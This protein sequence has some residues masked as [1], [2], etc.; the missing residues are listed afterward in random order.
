[1]NI[2]I[3]GAAGFIGYHTVKEI[4][5]NGNNVVGLDNLNDYYSV[6]LK[7][8]R[9]NDLKK[10]PYSKNFKFYRAD[11]ENI[12]FLKKIFKKHNFKIVINLAA[13]AG[14]RYSLKNP[15]PYIKSN[16][17]GFVNLLEVCKKNKIE[18]FIFASSSS[19]YGKTKKIKF[20]EN[21]KAV[22]PVS[23]YAS[24]K[25]CNEIIAHSYSHLYNMQ[26][27][28]LRF[29]TV[30]GAW[31]RPDMAYFNFVSRILNG[32]EIEIYNYGNHT[33]DFSYIDHIVNG[34]LSVVKNNKYKNIKRK[35]YEI[36]NLANGNPKKLM[37]F[38]STIEKI[39]NKNAKKKYIGLQDGDVEKTY[40]NVK[41]FKSHYKIKKSANLKYGI[42]KFITWYKKYYKKNN[43]V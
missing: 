20:S 43:Y 23:L 12:S 1:M 29:F 16:I 3:T 30:Y 18:H 5:R 19:V 38:I 14:V 15:N 11:L 17:Q 31:G 21:D 25:R 40:A 41:K 36:Y 2:L 42:L 9:L 37:S 33:R 6:K 39:L 7:K 24:T 13:Q 10:N 32:K 34:I 28:G 27:T 35:K 8:D 22:S 4:I 26:I